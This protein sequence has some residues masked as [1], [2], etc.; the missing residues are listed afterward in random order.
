MEQL[1]PNAQRAKNAILLI[2]II[3]IMNVVALFLD[4]LEYQL[5]NTS[6]NGGEI[7]MADAEANDTRQ[8]IWAIAYICCYIISIVTFLQWFRR[9]YLNLST[10]VTN[11]EHSE[12]FTLWCWFTPVLN[13]YVPYNIM[14]TLY[15]KTDEVLSDKLRLYIHGLSSKFVGWW[16]ALW[17]I[18]GVIDRIIF[19]QTKNA[20]TI[21]KLFVC[22]N[23]GIISS[24]LGIFLCLVTIKVITDYSKIE[25]L[26]FELRE[27]TKEEQ[28]E[29]ED[30]EEM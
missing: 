22:T 12:N 5:L 19:A 8:Q 9:A 6:I 10:Q 3:L 13:F 16:W 21:P 24:I 18:N 23:L 28:E 11:L 29:E 17:I 15:K 4:L 27:K 1:R 25:P 14:K 7:S 30:K 26:F 2:W 20:D